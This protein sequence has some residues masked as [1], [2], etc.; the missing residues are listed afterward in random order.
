MTGREILHK[1]KAAAGFCPSTSDTGK[2]KSKLCRHVTHGFH[3]VKG[4]ARHAMEDYVVAQF[5]KVKDTELGLFAIF[6]GHL[7]HDVPNY[8][9]SNLFD[10]I[11]K[12]QDFWTHT[13]NAIKKAYEITDDKILE[14]V[15]D[16]GSGGSTA[17]TAILMNCEKLVIANVGDSRAVVSRNGVA[18][19]L[20]VDH[21]PNKEREAIEKK[22]G[23]VSNL[24]G[25]VPRVD[26]QLAVARAFGDR[27][28][29]AHVSSEPHVV[30]EI[31]EPDTEFLILASDGLWKV[32]TNQEAV[33]SIRSVKDAQAAAKHLTEAALN[34]KSKDDIS[35]V[36]VR[37]L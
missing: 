34:R 6:D 21:E 13:E 3:L 19:Q 14:K 9:Q 11:L 16:L 2:G 33:D 5:R 30:V 1:M 20:S 37:F 27:S 8:L 35:C 31:I 36:V 29:K 28:L 18:K 25:D 23:F 32:M 12:Q 15:V 22:G 7:G 24:P 4:K 10:N 26:G 17:V